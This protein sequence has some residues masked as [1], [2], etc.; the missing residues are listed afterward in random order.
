M[1]C[2]S[3]KIYNFQPYSGM[4]V[5]TYLS[6]YAKLSTYYKALI[7]SFRLFS[8][9]REYAFGESIQYAA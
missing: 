5:L 7:G 9:F 4:F 2:Q 1:G 3:R 8:T 6:I